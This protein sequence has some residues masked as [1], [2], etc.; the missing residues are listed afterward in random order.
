MPHVKVIPVMIPLRNAKKVEQLKFVV[1][2]VSVS[3]VRIS[4]LG[5]SNTIAAVLSVY[6]LSLIDLSGLTKLLMHFWFYEMRID[7]EF[8]DK[9]ELFYSIL[10]AGDLP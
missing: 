6:L 7:S 9:V 5:F 3:W 1:V 10:L 4:I 2:V 8:R